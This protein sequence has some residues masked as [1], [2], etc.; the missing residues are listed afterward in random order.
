VA[1]LLLE[2]SIAAGAELKGCWRA[3]SKIDKVHPLLMSGPLPIA[4]LAVG[5]FISANDP[6]L[7]A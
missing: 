2:L 3:A 4:A 5:T 1:T 7:V 6:C